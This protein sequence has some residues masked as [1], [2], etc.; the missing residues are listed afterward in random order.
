MAESELLIERTD[1]YIVLT[2]NRSE[3]R[4]ALWPQ[5]PADI[6]DVFRTPKQERGK[7]LE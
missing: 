7:T 4:N 1:A 2:L 6:C 3:A 5:L